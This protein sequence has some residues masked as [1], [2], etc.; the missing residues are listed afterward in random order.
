MEFLEGAPDR[1][2]LIL[3]SCIGSHENQSSCCVNQSKSAVTV[4]PRWQQKQKGDILASPFRVLPYRTCIVA[5]QRLKSLDLAANDWNGRGA[6]AELLGLLD[7]RDRRYVSDYNTC[8]GGTYLLPK[9]CA[10]T[11]TDRCL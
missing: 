3:E 4:Y 6:V 7:Q 2:L 11:V 1:D 9:G 8:T 10:R 5:T